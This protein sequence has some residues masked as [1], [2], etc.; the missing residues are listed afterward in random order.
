MD[1]NMSAAELRRW[2]ARCDAEAKDALT[3][4]GEMRDGLSAVAESQ[5]WLE[6]RHSSGRDSFDIAADASD[7]A[8]PSALTR[9]RAASGGDA[10]HCC[11]APN[12]YSDERF[13]V[14]I[15]KRAARGIGKLPPH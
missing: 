14:S 15:V 10:R 8:F 4:G 9:K 12:C 5:E 7:I 13:W 2:A 1:T 6:L 11:T 3:S